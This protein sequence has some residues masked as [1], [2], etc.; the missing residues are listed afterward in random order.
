MID[1]L[2]AAREAHPRLER[3]PEHPPDVGELVAQLDPGAGAAP[4]LLT[5][6]EMTAKRKQ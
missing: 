5:I 4:R 6:G 3:P 1:T 2:L